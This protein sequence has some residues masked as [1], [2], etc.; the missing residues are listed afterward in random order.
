MTSCHSVSVPIIKPVNGLC[1][2]ACS[3]CYTSGLKRRV[4]GNRMRSDV[5]KTVVDFFCC[6]Q[7]DIEF[8]W[9]GGE[10]LLAGLDFYREAVSLQRTWER[11]G[12]KIANFVQTNATLVTPEWAS[13]FAEHDFHVGVSLDGPREFHDS[14][15][16]YSSGSGSYVDVMKGIELLRTAGVFNGIICG[17]ST[18]NH[19]FPKEIF[20]FFVSEN[21][22]KLKFARVKSIGHCAD[23]SSLAI[24]PAQYVDFMATIFDLWL[25][26]DDAEVEIRDIQSVVNLILGGKQRE[27][28]YMGQCDQ[29]VTVYSDGSIYG[30]DS[31]PKSDILHF[32]NVSGEP[33][34]VRSNPRLRIFQESLDKRKENCRA[35]EWHFI[36]RGGVRKRLLCATRFYRADERCLRKPEA[37]LRACF[38]QVEIMRFDIA[39]MRIPNKGGENKKTKSRPTLTKR[40]TPCRMPTR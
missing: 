12:R 32:G 11:Q 21:I 20:N 34:R 15:R 40:Y 5:L 17:V 1:N 25:E 23:V 31:F 26:L 33:S 14:T 38:N 24:Q 36:C 29:F 8:I 35:C 13:F 37:I 19:K 28:I 10:P 16:R 7:D 3:Y 27:C 22:K 4:D 2:L 30:C 9:H 39:V 18:A 6:G